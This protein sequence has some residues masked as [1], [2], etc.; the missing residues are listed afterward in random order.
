MP[1]LARPSSG[2]R[3]H[4]GADTRQH[5]LPPPLP[6]Q[7]PPATGCSGDPWGQPGGEPG[8]PA[9]VSTSSS[10]VSRLAFLEYLRKSCK[11][12]MGGGGEGSMSRVTVTQQPASDGP[13]HA[14]GSAPSA[15][16]LFSLFFPPPSNTRKW[17]P[18]VDFKPQESK[19][20][21]NLSEPVRVPVSLQHKLSS[22]FINP[23]SNFHI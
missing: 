4:T 1:S 23:G 2:C 5:P 20:R 11:A 13:C 17:C 21:P 8:G 15:S 14:P 19:V 3:G 12:N 18:Y 9:G 10:D 7:T 16:A 22:F 6:G